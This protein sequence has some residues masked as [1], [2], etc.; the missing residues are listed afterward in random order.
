MHYY[1]VPHIDISIGKIYRLWKDIYFAE[2]L[3][4]P[5]KNTIS[6]NRKHL[7]VFN[8]EAWV[9]S[10]GLTP[11]SAFFGFTPPNSIMPPHRDPSS[12]PDIIKQGFDYHPWALNIPLTCD[13]GSKIVWHRV[14]TGSQTQLE[15]ASNSPYN[16][17][18]V[19]MADLS[20]LIEVA[21]ICLDRPMLISTFDWHSVVNTTSEPRLIFSLRFEPIMSLADA[22]KLFDRAL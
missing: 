1:P 20:D 17:V 13:V 10:F 22:A 5:R 19:P 12:N 15:G 3:A 6:V 4:R 8:D 18:R 21:S 7:A 14:K 9:S 11:V 16:N 2:H